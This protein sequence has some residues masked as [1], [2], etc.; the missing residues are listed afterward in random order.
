ML[1]VL[2]A[3][4]VASQ[5]ERPRE[6]S[7]QQGLRCQL[8]LVRQRERYAEMIEQIDERGLPRAREL[9]LVELDE[10]LRERARVVQRAVR[11]AGVDAE[12]FGEM[13]ELAARGI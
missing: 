2:Q 6:V 5:R 13:H 12:L 11:G 7:K 8:P 1:V 3:T 9:L 10:Y 4:A